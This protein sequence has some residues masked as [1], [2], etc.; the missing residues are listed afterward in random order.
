MSQ[1][2]HTYKSRRNQALLIQTRWGTAVQ[3][4]FSNEEDF[5]HE[6]TIYRRLAG[7]DIPSASVISACHRTLTLTK[8][9]GLTMLEVLEQQE[10]SQQCNMAVWDQLVDWLVRFES[11]TGCV[12]MDMNL[13]NFIYDPNKY[14][15]YGIDFEECAPGNLLDVAATLAAFVRLYAPENT[16]V[17]KQVSNHLLSLFSQHLSVDMVVLFQLSKQKEILLL[18]RRKK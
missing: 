16:P 4:I 13:R 1:T 17:K 6:L 14:I 8:L 18:Q 10:Q 12:M 5:L 7:S 9:P 3:K 2:L 15:L 11:V